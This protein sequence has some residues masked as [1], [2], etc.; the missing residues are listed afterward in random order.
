V[1]NTFVD[2]LYHHNVPR[3]LD[4]LVNEVLYD[5]PE[6]PYPALAALLKKKA[7]E[8]EEEIKAGAVEAVAPKAASKK[9]SKKQAQANIADEEA[10][11]TLGGK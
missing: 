10:F 11:P 9:A 3:T 6:D 8:Y 4:E 1:R 5:M 7:D 2:Y